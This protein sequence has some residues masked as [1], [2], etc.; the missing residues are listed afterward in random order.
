[1]ELIERMVTALAYPLEF[2]DDYHPSL[3]TTSNNLRFR[4]NDLNEL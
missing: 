1:M 2:D 4:Q 3:F